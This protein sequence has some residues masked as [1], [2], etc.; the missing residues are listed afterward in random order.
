MAFYSGH[1]LRD[2]L[3]FIVVAF[4]EF[5]LGEIPQVVILGF[6]GKSVELELWRQDGELIGKGA[7]TIPEQRMTREDQ[8]IVFADNFGSMRPVRRIQTTTSRAGLVVQ[9]K[10]P[11]VGVYEVRLIVDGQ[12]RQSAPFR[13]VAR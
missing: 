8:G 4:G 12:M 11:A 13:V 10:R 1:R 2:F 3:S 7:F 5:K 6:G 9:L